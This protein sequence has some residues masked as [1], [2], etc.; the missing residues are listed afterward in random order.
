VD[1]SSRILTEWRTAE[2]K[3]KKNSHSAARENEKL[4]DAML[5]VR[6]QRSPSVALL[7]HVSTAVTNRGHQEKEIKVAEKDCA[8]L[9]NKRRKAEEAV[10]RS[11]VEYY[12]LCIRAERARVDWEI[13]ILRGSSMLQS[14]ENQRLSHLK[15]YAGNY[16]K[17]TTEMNPVYEKIMER[18]APQVNKCDIQKDMCVLKTIRRS[19]E[20]PSEQLLPDFYSEHTTLAMNRERRKQ[21]LVKLLQLIRQDLERERRSRNGLKGLTQTLSS[22]DNQNIADKLYHVSKKLAGRRKREI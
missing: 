19:A 4:Q 20:G 14:L 18:L 21:S 2:A 13:G 3:A 6:I 5:D 12:T 7:S 9:D 10:K 16:L 17:L 1:K 15:T 11:D 8:K 22:P